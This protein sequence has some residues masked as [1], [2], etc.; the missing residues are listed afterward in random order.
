MPTATNTP[1]VTPTP[2][3]A[4]KTALLNGMNHQW[5]TYNNCGPAAL[6]IALGFFGKQVTQGQLNDQGFRPMTSPSHLTS[7][8]N[9]ADFGAQTR[10]YAIP[11]TREQTLNLLKY[12]LANDIPVIVLQRLNLDERISHYRVAEGYD[13][14]AGVIIFDDPYY[15]AGYRLSYDAFMARFPNTYP[16]ASFMPVYQ[17]AQAGL[18]ERLMAEGGAAPR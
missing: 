12:L 2:T 8:F 10:S 4:P 11:A 17:P 1:T 14:S 6:A 16:P 3:A 5:Q 9:T 13:D 18:V 7:K 15:G